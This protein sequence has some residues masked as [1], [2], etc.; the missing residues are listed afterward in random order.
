IPGWE[1]V[2]DIL[3]LLCDIAKSEGV[4]L[5][6]FVLFV[7]TRELEARRLNKKDAALILGVSVPTYRRMISL[8]Q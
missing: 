6:D 2:N 7:L 8:S 4:P 1:E 5:L 3:M